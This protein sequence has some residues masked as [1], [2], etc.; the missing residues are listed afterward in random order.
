MLLAVDVGNTNITFGVYENENLRFVS[1]MA[2]DT[3]R[4]EDQYAVEISQILALHGVDSASVDGAIVSSVVPKLSH[5]IPAA[6]RKLFHIEALMVGA[7]TVPDLQIVTD[8][9]KET[10]A[11]LLVDCVSAKA[12][13]TC[14]CIVIDMGTAT[15]L[16]ILDKHGRFCGAVIAPGLGISLDA[17]V[18]NAALLSSVAAKAPEKVIGLNTTQCI[19]SGII[20]GSAAMLDGLC[21]RIEEEMGAS[22]S[23]V[24][25]GGHAR[26]VVRH[27]RREIPYRETFLLDGLKIIF[28]AWQARS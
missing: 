23:V 17:L 13:C 8:N 7:D 21:S 3:S 25:T 18:S 22:C 14:P 20:H 16:L 9:A 4:L 6:I 19:Q 5:D 11:D 15:K 10:G 24:A 27:C 1:R 12:T 28:D 2:T 26:E